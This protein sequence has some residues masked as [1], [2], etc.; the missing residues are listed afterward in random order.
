MDNKKAKK[1]LLKELEDNVLRIAKSINDTREIC[2]S[3]KIGKAR[4]HLNS[5]LKLNLESTIAERMK[6]FL[7]ALQRTMTA[8]DETRR[9][10]HSKRLKSVREDI[11]G[12]LKK[13]EHQIN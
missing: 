7:C 10:F 5:V 12:I 2:P 8:L 1:Q 6:L 11:S 3:V 4:E 13:Y 9:D